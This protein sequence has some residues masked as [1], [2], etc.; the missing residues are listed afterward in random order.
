MLKPI[1]SEKQYESYLERIYVLMQTD[2]KADSKESDEVEIL[3]ILVKN[4]EDTHYA[5]EKPNPIE[6]IRFRLDQMGKSESFL[7]KILGASRKSEILSGK[8]KLNLPQ[9]RKLSNELHI[10]ADVLVQE[11]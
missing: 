8:R 2:L 1:K 10:S 11:Y 3:S 9:I 5:I 7:S 6:A 4:Y